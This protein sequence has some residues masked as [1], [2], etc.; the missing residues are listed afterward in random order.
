[1]RKPRTRTVKGGDISVTGAPGYRVTALT[2]MFQKIIYDGLVGDGFLR[3]F[4][5]T[6]DLAG[7]RMIF[8][9]PE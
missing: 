3:N 7:D 9:S 6:Y 4:T 8:A 5:T 1:M 2:V